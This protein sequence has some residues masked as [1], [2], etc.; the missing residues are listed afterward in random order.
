MGVF[1][2]YLGIRRGPA[3][4]PVTRYPFACTVVANGKRVTGNESPVK[5]RVRVTR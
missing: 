3:S 4:L 1:K 5:S 2:L